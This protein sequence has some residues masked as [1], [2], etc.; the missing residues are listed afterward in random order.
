MKFVSFTIIAALGLLGCQKGDQATGV[1]SLE[2]KRDSVSYAIGVNIGTNLLRDSVD[3]STSSLL[4]GL[5]DAKL[6]SSERMCLPST[7]ERVL[8][9]YQ[10][11][12]TTRRMENIQKQGEANL[13]K[14]ADWL[15]ENKKK[16]GVIE[17]GSGLQYKVIRKGNGPRPTV[18]QTVTAHYKGTLTDGT[19]FDSSYDRNEPAEFPLSGVIPGWTE[20]LQLMEIGS[21]YELYI[22]P[23]LGY[24]ENGSG[25]IPPNS[26]LIFEVEL[27]AIK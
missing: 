7:M 25:P 8:M 12:L 24:G 3:F 23:S 18:Q 15:A 16:E 20:G 2:T 26:V 22:P 17:T 9:A 14:G 5:M 4:Q 1:S 13:Q 11:E 27:L 10:Q 19:P 21:K 6:D